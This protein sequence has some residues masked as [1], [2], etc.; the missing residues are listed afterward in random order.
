MNQT[1]KWLHLIILF[2]SLALAG[3]IA[4]GTLRTEVTE[5]SKMR[6][7]VL[8]MAK[9]LAYVKGQLDTKWGKLPKQGE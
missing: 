4:Y 8:E 3:G 2:C 9:D 5:N 6:V 1:P 7:V